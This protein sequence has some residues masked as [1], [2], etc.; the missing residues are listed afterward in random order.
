MGDLSKNFSLS[1][2][3]CRDGC[4]LATGVHRDLIA[5]CQRLRDNVGR[6]VRVNCGGRCPKHN[7]EVG[8]VPRSEHI[9]TPER[10]IVEA[11]DLVIDGLTSEQMFREAEK[12]PE[13]QAGGIGAYFPERLVHV[14]VRSHPA[15][16]G[17]WHGR[18]ISIEDFFKRL[19]GPGG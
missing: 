15:Q 8:G 17:R 5:G 7:A 11:A 2:F 12:I 16:W 3:S 10:L 1:E 19:N 13:F 18:Y 14:D 4:G 6:S 9:V